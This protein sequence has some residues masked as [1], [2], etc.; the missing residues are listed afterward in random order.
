MILIS[1]MCITL[2]CTFLE[3]LKQFLVTVAY[4]ELTIQ[5]GPVPLAFL[6][7]AFYAQRLRCSMSY[8]RMPSQTG[9]HHR[10]G[11]RKLNTRS[12]FTVRN[13]TIH[14]TELFTTW[15]GHSVSAAKEEDAKGASGPGH[16]K[17]GFIH[18]FIGW[19]QPSGRQPARH[20]YSV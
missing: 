16:Q 2:S 12:S 3:G 8:F 5:I 4:G 17:R 10:N 14:Q 1:S 19:Y 15:W 11:D 20:R 13:V 18:S 7:P 6:S 9:R